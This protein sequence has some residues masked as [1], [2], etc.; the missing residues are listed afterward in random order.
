MKALVV[1]VNFLLTFFFLNQHLLAQDK[2]KIAV[3]APLAI[4]EAFTNNEFSI[5]GT[6]LP[7]NMFAG[8][9]FYN[10]VMMGVDSLNKAGLTNIVL[11][12][13]DTKSNNNTIE[14]IVNSVGFSNTKLI[15]ASLNQRNDIKTLANYANVNQIPFVS[16]TLPNDGGISNNPYFFLFN[17]TL[18]S[19]CKA[20]L[21]HLQYHYSKAN[22]VY[23]SKEGSFE[24]MV[25]E[26]CTQF[27]KELNKPIAWKQR[28]L[29]DSFSMADIQ[30]LLDSAKPNVIIGGATNEA[31][32]NRIISAASNLKKYKISIV[33]LPTWDQLK[34][35]E[36]LARKN[37]EVWY[38]NSY[39]FSKNNRII[40]KIDANYKTKFAAKPSDMVYKGFEAF[41]KFAT[42]AAKGNG[43]FLETINNPTCKIF[44]NTN[45]IPIKQNDEAA[46]IDYFENAGIE[47]LRKL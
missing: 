19:H 18:R 9:E 30:I 22:V 10:G 40:V 21:Q 11:K 12:I 45:F 47:F 14:S 37:L 24:K 41:V 43:S 2:I 1:A 29:T 17:P 31:F 28:V 46:V 20:M 44:S 6:S 23:L 3:F 13:Y 34:I 38:G 15:I 33:G 42:I 36:K 35:D 5:T 39:N 7:K 4:D 27:N 16:A 32:V 26:H 25:S 8:I